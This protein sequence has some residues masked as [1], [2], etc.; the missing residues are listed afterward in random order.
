MQRWAGR[1][2]GEVR[3]IMVSSCEAIIAQVTGLKEL[4]DAFRR[5]ARMPGVNPRPASVSRIVREI[6][7]LYEGLAEGLRVN[8][9][10]PTEDIVGF[11]DPVLLRQALVNLIDNAIDAVHDAGTITLSAS[12]EGD[13]IILEVAD[14]GV[15]LPTDD[16][17]MLLQPF[18]STK[19]R[20]SGM[21][22]A[23]VHR[24]VADHGGTL[25]LDN[26]SPRGTVARIV[27]TD[28]VATASEDD[29]TPRGSE[30]TDHGTA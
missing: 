2:D 15:G 14:T 23:L 6:G 9:G 21:G 13:D 18:Y 30:T 27:L 25:R 5:Y 7:S 8:I 29:A 10:L 22:L 11:I 17:E 28:S 16:T 4:V 20:G 12:R 26:R 3:D 19:G 24:I 1:L